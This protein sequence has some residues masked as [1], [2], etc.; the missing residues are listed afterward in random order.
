MFLVDSHCHLNMLDLSKDGGSLNPVI[1]R[2]QENGVGYLLNVCVSL[3]EFPAIL[4]TAEAYPFVAASVGL[5]PNAEEAVDADKLIEL[6]QPEKVIAV[7]E[8]GLDYFRSTSDLDWQRARFRAHI[9]AAKAL[10]KPLIIHTRES[11]EDTIRI[12]REEGAADAG[13]VMHCFTEDWDIAKQAMEMGFYISISGIVTFK[14]AHSIQDVARRMPLDCL[15][16]E[17]DSPYLA[18]VPYRRK[19]NEPSYVRHTAA[20][21]ADMRGDNLE[22]FAEAT[23]NNFFNLFKGAVKP[24]V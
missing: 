2:A 4:K 9:Q 16:I 7:G 22:D 14:N 11:R 8:T 10:K 1:A 15:L 3:A 5:H 18:P 24:D 20:F 13:G 12:M 6:G 21:I 23:T 17:T 19:P